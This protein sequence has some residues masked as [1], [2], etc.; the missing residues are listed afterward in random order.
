[1]RMIALLLT[2]SFGLLAQVIDLGELKR[3]EEE[4][5][6]KVGEVKFVLTDTN[7]N[8]VGTEGK[9][10]N[11]VQVEPDVAAEGEGEPPSETDTESVAPTKPK[12]SSK[13][14]YWQDQKKAIEKRIQ[15]LSES[16]ESEQSELNQLWTDFYNMG[17][18]AFDQ[19]AV[20]VK[21]SQKTSS[22]E[23]KKIGLRQAQDDLAA[24][25]ERA[26]REGVPPGWLR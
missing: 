5:R 7:L 9:K 1:M 12:E 11:F 14:E 16:I 8:D 17:D 25:A 3:Q 23:S 6:K 19:D 24:L 10:L 15:F 13:P 20:K 21:I 26:R 4:R 2:F 22:L 18:N